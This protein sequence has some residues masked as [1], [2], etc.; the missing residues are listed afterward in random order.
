MEKIFNAPPR[1]ALRSLRSNE[2]ECLLSASAVPRRV[3]GKM[4][5]DRRP[6]RQVFFLPLR[7][8]RGFRDQ[9]FLFFVEND[10]AIE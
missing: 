5:F 10:S 2:A 3:D 7:G 8:G 9:S 1:L 6:V 4:V